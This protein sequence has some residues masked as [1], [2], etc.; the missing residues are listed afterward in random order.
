MD[1]VFVRLIGGLGNQLFQWAAAASFVGM[2]GVRALSVKPSQHSTLDDLAP[3]MLRHASRLERLS[4]GDCAYIRP[5]LLQRALSDA[6]RSRAELAKSRYHGQGDELVD[7]FAI[8]PEG[9]RPC[10]LQG[11]FQDPSWY[12]GAV[13]SV[14]EGLLAHAPAGWETSVDAGNYTILS[15]RRGDYLPLG[16]DLSVQ[17]YFDALAQIEDDAPLVVVGDDATFVAGLG[18]ELARRGRRVI[19][20]PLLHAHHAVSDFWSIAAAKNV[21]MSNSTFCWWATRVATRRR[22]ARS[23]AGTVVFP[24]Q[25]VGGEGARLRQPTWTPVDSSRSG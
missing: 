5:P 3:G 19:D 9:I 4:I 6:L 15:S 13:E 16:W 25:W 20:L 24:D 14:I 8:R 12:E 23:V 22:Q 1:K 10:V 18:R 21:V 11:Y 2:D 7:A 17:Y